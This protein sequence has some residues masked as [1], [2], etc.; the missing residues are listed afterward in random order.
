ML[1]EIK[2]KYALHLC[3]KPLKS[4]NLS[5]NLIPVIHAVH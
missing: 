5:A 2:I 4:A 3:F 1:C